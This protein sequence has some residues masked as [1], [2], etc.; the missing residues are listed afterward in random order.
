[1]KN[2]VV[3]KV[4]DLQAPTRRWLQT[5]L[6]RELG[7]EEVVTITAFP[8]H[9]PRSNR[10]EDTCY[11]IARRARI[12]GSVKNAPP[13]LSTNPDHFEGFGSG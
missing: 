10:H 8:S 11:A 9:G 12:I 4:H 5:V 2:T 3:R 7:D 1:M 6:G 13:D